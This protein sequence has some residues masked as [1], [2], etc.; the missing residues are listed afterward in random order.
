V[1]FLTVGSSLPFDRLV[2]L[3]DEVAADGSIQHR[4]FA[5]IGSGR[6]KPRN[7]ECVDFLSRAEYTARF[8]EAVAI[9]SHAGIGTISTALQ[10]NRPILV[11]PRKKKFGELVDDHQELTA[12]RF[13]EMGHVLAFSNRTELESG[14]QRLPEFVP[15]PRQP[16]A[17]GIAE[18]IGIYLTQLSRSEP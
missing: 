5:Q 2:A 1:I 11:M 13:A 8:D 15:T 18:A 10:A 17:R 4:V 16:N 9:V 6:Y 14:L 3:V 12:Q 7:F